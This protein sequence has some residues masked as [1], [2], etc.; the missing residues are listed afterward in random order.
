MPDFTTFITFSALLALVFFLVFDGRE[1]CEL[2]S[3]LLSAVDLLP[4]RTHILL[5]I[6]RR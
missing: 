2:L 1:I 4:L 6:I 5:S 3:V